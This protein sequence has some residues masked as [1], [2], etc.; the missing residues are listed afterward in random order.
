MLNDACVDFLPINIMLPH[1]SWIRQWFG[2]NTT[3]KPIT[4]LAYSYQIVL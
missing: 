3:L 2:S 1:A 4:K